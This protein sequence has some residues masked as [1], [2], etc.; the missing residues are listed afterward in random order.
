[1]QKLAD[2]D[3]RSLKNWMERMLTKATKAAVVPVVFIMFSCGDGTEKTTPS[4]FSHLDTVKTKAPE[5]KEDKKNDDEKKDGTS[6]SPFD[7]IKK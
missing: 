5:K 6:F 4:P 2:A 1:M 3:Y 7:N